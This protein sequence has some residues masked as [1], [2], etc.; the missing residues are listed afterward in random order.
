MCAESTHSVT[1]KND[2]P[3]IKLFF[4]YLIYLSTLV[5]YY[6]V[7]LCNIALVIMKLTMQTKLALNSQKATFASQVLR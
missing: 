2:F 3:G 4:I 5:F 6:R 7:S 1:E